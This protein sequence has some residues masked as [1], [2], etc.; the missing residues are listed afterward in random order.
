M[1][2]YY[3]DY[4]SGVII[5]GLSCWD[6]GKEKGNYYLGRGLTMNWLVGA[7]PQEGFFDVGGLP[8]LSDAALLKL[9][10]R[11]TSCKRARPRW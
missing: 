4:N 1:E 6:N 2:L 10:G 9:L 11:Q 8:V 7:G 5:L 3:W